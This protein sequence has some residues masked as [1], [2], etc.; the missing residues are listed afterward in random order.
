MEHVYCGAQQSRLAQDIIV[1]TDDFRIYN[2]V[3]EFGGK[4]EMTS[5]KHQS[6]TDRMAEVASRV[7][8][9]I[10]VNVQGDEPEITGQVIDQ[11]VALLADHPEASVATLVYPIDSVTAANPNIVK[12][13]CNS[14]GFALY[15]SRAPIPYVRDSHAPPIEYLGHIG[16]YAYRRDFLLHYP[17]L[18]PSFLEKCEKLE[19]LRVLENGYSI[20]T[21][22]SDYRSR[23]ID[24]SEDYR[25]FVIRYRNSQAKSNP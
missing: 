10:F 14:H 5:D 22:V 20:L 11:V 25:E 17:T 15:F 12:V 3:R 9:D 4:V 21:A 23:G 7:P 24:T 13:V 2:A 6:G 1:A 8:G 16:I 19:Q 18:K